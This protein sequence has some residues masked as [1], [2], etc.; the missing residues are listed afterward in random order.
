M[1]PAGLSAIRQ[2]ELFPTYRNRLYN[3]RVKSEI[4]VHS[5]LRVLSA[6]GLPGF[7]VRRGD[8]DAGAIFIRLNRLDGTSVV[9]GPAPAGLTHLDGGRGWVPVTDSNGQIDEDIERYLSQEI[10]F[11]P[12]IWIVEVEDRLG[13]HCLDSW[14]VG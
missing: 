12:D 4:W 6:Q 7:V 13:R 5:Y 1:P 9:F 3:M 2:S 10:E 14:L 11:D 8:G